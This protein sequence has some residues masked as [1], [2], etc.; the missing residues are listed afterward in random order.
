MKMPEEMNAEWVEAIAGAGAPAEAEMRESEAPTPESP[1]D[2][3]GYVRGLV[4]RPHDYGTCVYAMSLAAVAAL[5][6]V[7]SKL[8]VT[9][10]QAFCADLDVLRR[11]RRV[12]WGRLL[13]FEDLLYPQYRNKFQGWDELLE[14]NRGRLAELA[15][16]KLAGNPGA[17]PAV[18]AH[19][20][21]LAANGGP[22]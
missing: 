4:E 10:Y 5:N 13:N 21:A 17:A 22:K 6:L 11:T 19:W 2:L 1:E 3:A 14:E 15:S 7:A 9:G 18:L 8:G 16:E 12:E 20:R